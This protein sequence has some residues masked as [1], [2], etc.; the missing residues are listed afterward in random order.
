MNIEL[1]KY[2]PIR[3]GI[4]NDAAVAGYPETKYVSSDLTLQEFLS[5]N[6]HFG[7]LDDLSRGLPLVEAGPFTHH[8]IR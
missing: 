1:A 4:R 5:L 7:K 6:S 8:L 3:F 2:E